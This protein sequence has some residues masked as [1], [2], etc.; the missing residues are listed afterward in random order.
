MSKHDLAPVQDFADDSPC[1][2]IW[3]PANVS[4]ILRRFEALPGMIWLREKLRFHETQISSQKTSSLSGDAQTPRELWHL[5]GEQTESLKRAP[6]Q[7]QP[8]AVFSAE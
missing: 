5:R 8:C 2:Y 3:T 1:S 7:S 4:I 6:R